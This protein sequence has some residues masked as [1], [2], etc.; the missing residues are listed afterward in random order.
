MPRRKP[1]TLLGSSPLRSVGFP[2]LWVVL[3][4]STYSLSGCPLPPLVSFATFLQFPCLWLSGACHLVGCINPKESWATADP[5]LRSP[6]LSSHLRAPAEG[7][8]PRTLFGEKL[9]TRR[10]VGIV[11]VS[12]GSLGDLQRSRRQGTREGSR[13]AS[14]HKPVA[15]QLILNSQIPSSKLPWP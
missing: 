2:Y 9:S 3:L 12:R 4:G 7:W 8:N 14:S 5:A 15:D 11:K 1:G 6:T 13:H 10:P